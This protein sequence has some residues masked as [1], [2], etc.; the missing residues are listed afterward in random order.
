[1]QAFLFAEALDVPFEK[2]PNLV[3]FKP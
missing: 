1:L 3:G 2:A